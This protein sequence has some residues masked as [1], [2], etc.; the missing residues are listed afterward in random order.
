MCLL[1]AR[2]RDTKTSED[3]DL[4][5]QW[6]DS[7][8]VRDADTRLLGWL[9]VRGMLRGADRQRSGC[10]GSTCRGGWGAGEVKIGRKWKGV[11]CK[12]RQKACIAQAR[13][14]GEPACKT[15]L[16]LASFPATWVLLSVHLN[17]P[18]LP[19]SLLPLVS[20]DVHTVLERCCQG[21]SD[22]VTPWL[23]G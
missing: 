12:D 17:Q 7:A 14:R 20:P 15:G 8:K 10:P 11:S 1:C 13:G 19:P 18:P 22:E 9:C 16:D 4:L 21:G 3:T 5:L 6:G 2:P 23:R